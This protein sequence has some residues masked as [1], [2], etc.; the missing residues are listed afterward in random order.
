M[1]CTRRGVNSTPVAKDY[2]LLMGYYR[3]PRTWRILR[4]DGPLVNRPDEG[5]GR[6]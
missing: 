3:D 5:W 2:P 4:Y 1:K 6:P